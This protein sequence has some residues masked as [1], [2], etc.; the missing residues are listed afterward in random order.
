M[1]D[2]GGGRISDKRRRHIL[3][4]TDG[5]IIKHL[6]DYIGLLEELAYG[7]WFEK[8]DGRSGKSKLY[9]EIPDRQALE[10]LVEHGMGKVAQRHEIT[11]EDGGGIQIVPWLPTLEGKPALLDGDIDAEDKEIPEEAEEVSG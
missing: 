6:P 5:Y 10:F 1:P 9:K 4:R 7:V 3:D 8:I 2:K 11:G